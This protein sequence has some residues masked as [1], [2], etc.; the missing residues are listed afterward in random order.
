MFD[1][2]NDFLF[3]HRSRESFSLN[4]FKFHIPMSFGMTYFFGKKIFLTTKYAHLN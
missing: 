1:V 3:L 2:P 4:V